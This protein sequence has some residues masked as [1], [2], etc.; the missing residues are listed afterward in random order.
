MNNSLLH[1]TILRDI[2]DAATD[3]RD[4]VD[5]VQKNYGKS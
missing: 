2:V 5:D 4:T 1:E 3:I